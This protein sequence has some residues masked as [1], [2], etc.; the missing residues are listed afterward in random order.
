MRKSMII[1]GV[2]GALAVPNAAQATEPPTGADRQSASEECRFER[3]STA[4]TREA[5]AAKYGTNANRANAFGKCVSAKAREEAKEREA[6]E[7]GAAQTCKTE[8]GTTAE[9]EAAFAQKY[10]T[11]KNK[12]NAFGKCVSSA[13]KEAKATADQQDQETAKERKSAAKQCA[14]ERGTSDE[15]REAF[16]QKYGTNKNKRNAFGRCVS[17]VAKSS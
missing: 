10:G 8:R 11:N 3:G 13:A 2:F 17:Q 16:A 5:F 14:K 1:A 9:S 6:A 4:A 12:T 15:S 7:S